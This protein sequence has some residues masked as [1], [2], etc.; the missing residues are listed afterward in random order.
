MC[1]EMPD[2]PVNT[3]V[4]KKRIIGKMEGQEGGRRGTRGRWQ[5]TSDFNLRRQAV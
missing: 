1:K 2:I 4:D 5:K 3:G